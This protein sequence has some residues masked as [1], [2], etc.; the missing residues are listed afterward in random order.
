MLLA[1]L[2]ALLLGVAS[3]TITGLIPGIHI[4][5]IGVFLISLTASFLSFI[6]PIY[7]VV[8]IVSM[9]NGYNSHFY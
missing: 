9:A 3:G 1:L 6:N 2:A 7:F 5:L 8:F 4:N